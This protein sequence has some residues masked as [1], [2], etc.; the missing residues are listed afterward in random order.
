M[1][2]RRRAL[3]KHCYNII[4]EDCGGGGHLT[5]LR[6]QKINCCVYGVTLSSVYKGGEERAGQ[7]EEAR[8][9]GESY[10]HRE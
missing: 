3:P 1:F 7:G 2:Y 9:R 5:R 8:P 4:E 6:D 10:S